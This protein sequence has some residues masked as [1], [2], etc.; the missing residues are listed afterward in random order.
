MFNKKERLYIEDILPNAP[1]SG[2]YLLSNKLINNEFLHQVLIDIHSVNFDFYRHPKSF[3]EIFKSLSS[4]VFVVY[5]EKYAVGNF[6]DKLM[7]LESSGWR[8]L[9]CMEDIFKLDN[10][11]I[12]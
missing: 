12:T 1:I 8:T 7:Y 11:L 6:G 2:Y 10:W 5:K 9:P 4:G 3:E